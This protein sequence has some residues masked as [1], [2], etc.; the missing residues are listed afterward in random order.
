M[1]KLRISIFTLAISLIAFSCGSTKDVEETSIESVE[2]PISII[3]RDVTAEEFKTLIDKKVGVILDVRTKGEIAAGKIENAI[4]LDYYSD[5]FKDDVA[6]L[7]RD[8]PVYVYCRSGGRS[9]GAKKIM[10]SMGFKVVYNLKGGYSN[11]PYK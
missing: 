8:K 7:D 1:N 3:S 2:N 6:K 4:Q 5:T 9:G 11:W 10:T